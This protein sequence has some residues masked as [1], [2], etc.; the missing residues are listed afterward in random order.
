MCIFL[1]LDIDECQ[2]LVPSPCSCG[3]PGEACGAN[4]TNTVPSYFCTCAKGF[5]LRSGGT[6]CD[7]NFF[8]FELKSSRLNLIFKI[9]KHWIL[10]HG[11][12][13]INKWKFGFAIS[14]K[15]LSVNLGLALG[16]SNAGL[17]PQPRFI[18]NSGFLVKSILFDFFSK[19]MERMCVLHQQ[20]CCVSNIV[21]VSKRPRWSTKRLSR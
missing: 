8:G 4:C 14:A 2:T 9:L 19:W 5:Q 13:P 11:R 10:S 18:E 7:G 3:V 1:Y 16:S 17:A 20:H 15:L 6:I 12:I 21:I